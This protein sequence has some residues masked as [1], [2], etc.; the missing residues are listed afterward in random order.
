M[1]AVVLIFLGVGALFAYEPGFVFLT[2]P[3]TAYSLSL[4]EN[5]ASLSGRL[6][7]FG[8]NPASLFSDK[9]FEAS[10][11]YISRFG[12]LRYSSLLLLYNR[13]WFHITGAF[14]IGGV[15]DIEARQSPTDRPDY[16]FSSRD[17]EYSLTVS[18]TPWRFLSV[19]ATAKGIYEKL[20]VYDA[21]GSA[22]DIGLLVSH[23][24]VSFG[25]AVQNYGGSSRFEQYYFELPLTYKAAISVYPRDDISLLFGFT[26]PDYA[27]GV[28]NVAVEYTYRHILSLRGAYIIGGDSQRFAF[29]LGVLLGMFSFDYGYGYSASVLGDTYTLGVNFA[30]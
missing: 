29:G 14:F 30:L 12:E 19:G 3:G 24:W 8:S 17:I 5:T 6:S 2:T 22:F 28:E 21:R 4:G 9:K 13:N 23:R 10:C 25:V 26:K 7:L 11:S 1:S 20:S 18:A 16:L 15:S 27:S